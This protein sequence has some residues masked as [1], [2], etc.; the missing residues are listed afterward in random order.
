QL[1]DL[2]A[3]ATSLPVTEVSDGTSVS[4]NH[5][6]VIP[7][8]TTMAV[9][10]GV[11]KL[12]PRGPSR[13][14]H[15][16]IDH[17]LRSLAQD[18][19]ESAIGVILSGSGSD[20]SLGLGE[21]K[22]LGGITF[23]QDEQ[24]A[25]FPSMPL[26]AVN[27]GSA[28]FVLPPDRIAREL[29]HI[30]Q[31]PYLKPTNAAGESGGPA[32][33]DFQ[34]ILGLLHASS[35]VD[36]TN[37]RDKT[38]RRR[39]ARRMA[40][41]HKDSLRDYASFLE[42]NRPELDALYHD[43]LINVTSFFRD[44]EVFEALKQVV[45]P[46]ILK[47]KSPETPIRIWVPGCSTGQETYSLAI[48]LLEFLDQVPM[49]PPVQIFGTDINDSASIERA[50]T[51][52]YPESIE[53]EVSPERLHRFFSKEDRGY[54]VGKSIRDMC[55]FAKQNVAVDPP[56]SNLDL[57]S[58]RNLLIY[59]SNALQQRIIPTFHYALCGSGF[60][61][62]G[63]AESVGRFTDLFELV[64]PR[65]KIYAKSAAVTRPYPYF[66]VDP[67]RPPAPAE[68][69][70]PAQRLPTVADL[71][72]EADRIALNRY[73]PAGVLVNEELEV[74]QFRGRTRRYLEPPAG[75]ASY[76]LL[77][78]ARENLF[79]ALRTAIQEARKQNAAVRKEGITFRDEEQVRQVNLEVIP[80]K[81]PGSAHGGFLINFEEPGA[82]GT[83]PPTRA[84]APTAP[85][86][87][88]EA[89]QLRQEL[90]AARE[91]L[92]SIIEQ[93]SAANEELRS[94]NEEIL[95]AN[96]ELQSTNEELQTTKEEMQS[97]NE[98][99]TTVNEE[100][101]SR[102][103]E[104]AQVN[105][106]LTNLLSS[107]KIPI[108]MLGTDL[109][110]RR[111]T[112]A[113]GKVLNLVASDVGRPLGNIRLPLEVPDLEPL[114]LDVIASMAAKE[115]EVQDAGGHWYLMRQHP[116]RTAD[117][118]IDGATLVL[119]DIDE[120]RR[121]QEQVKASRDYAMAIVDTVQ[122]PLLI[123]S[124][125]LRVV[126]ASRSFYET[127]RVAPQESEG[128]FVYELGNGQWSGPRLR[129]L[130]EDILPGGSELTDIEVEHDFPRIGRR[131]MLLNA[132]RLS[133]EPKQTGMILLSFK[134]ITDRKHLE[135]QLRKHV[136]EVTDA[137]A[138]KDHFLAALSH[139]LRTPL[140]PVLMTA[141]ALEG[142]KDLPADVLEEIAIMR[143][144]IGLEA[145]LIDDLL[146]LT[147]I[148]RGKLELDLHPQN[149]CKLLE[150]TLRIC[151]ADIAG[152]ELHL[153][154]DRKST[155]CGMMADG[156]RLQ[157]VFWNLIRNA[158]KF[159][160]ADG[161]IAVQTRNDDRGRLIIEIADTGMGIEPELLPRLFNAFEQGGQGTTRRFG[162][163]GLGLAIAKAITEM[164][165]GSLRAESLG[166]GRGAT[167]TIELPT[168]AE[169]EK[170]LAEAVAPPPPPEVPAA[171]MQ[172][173]R[174]LVVED[175]ADTARLMSR[176]LESLGH[177]V[178]TAGDIR[179]A[180]ALAADQAFHVVIS[181]LGLPDGSGL[182]LMRQLKQEHGVKGIA[183]TG[184]G[185]EAD[186]E[187]TR[188]AGF[189]EHL[190]K[191]INFEQL[192]AAIARVA[193]GH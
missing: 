104:V 39:I 25:K 171:A 149:I 51:G 29:A 89:E 45:F 166:K 55:V 36:F 182:D 66:T 16:P 12:T 140:T 65:H 181:D 150:E 99:L 43:V 106:D 135:E 119:I 23:A 116:Y 62:L 69:K 127:F 185:M 44:P 42:G 142:R 111:F 177:A 3:K 30:G 159:T 8:N 57:V 56:F 100:L 123:L 190:V 7:P 75:E 113:A 132:R 163:L 110:I 9:V 18:R 77:R 81:L 97:T 122:D 38:L 130:L 86:D 98:E 1:T 152:K 179:T 136:T 28:D 125:D 141:S 186:R 87:R 4:P 84:P 112:P 139:E 175:H 67:H 24:S 176:L 73:A 164:H 52:F 188:A 183:L 14:Q 153:R 161:H 174:I 155:H 60:L 172:S 107:V 165:G 148:A 138:A 68:G 120:S 17:F 121:A 88:G 64:D 180:K 108:I 94:A 109:R 105:D 61:M 76:N 102:N 71:Q 35:G 59:L 192:Q 47:G 22:A 187:R 137:N 160:P 32:G 92:Q 184:Y 79:A 133:A 40:L 58:C 50:R 21:I 167:F 162:G 26:H 193:N 96:E 93:Q 20:G 10:Q 157:Q 85:A 11:L 6:Y 129:A 19:H 63:S 48:A 53:A 144:N 131:T 83:G 70:A 27:S 189:V 15:L 169:A 37:Y 33:D 80:V 156:P 91:Y 145:K 128:Q 74:L 90:A 72:K 5:V 46:Q 168:D 13:L 178:K 114:V 101:Q 126:T 2:L 147:R 143:R 173:L 103:L 31:H 118:R 34:K 41:H 115:R 170:L 134:D 49:R 124:S 151:E 82:P 146:D 95:S 117:N 78:M 54:R 191:P 158:I 154:L